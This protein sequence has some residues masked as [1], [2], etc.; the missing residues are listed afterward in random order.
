[1]CC[2]PTVAATALSTKAVL[3]TDFVQRHKFE[4]R[5]SHNRVFLLGNVEEPST[6]S[7][8]KLQDNSQKS[9]SRMKK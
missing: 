4:K 1:M 6:E 8:S 5:M 7:E 9:S 2:T 3:R